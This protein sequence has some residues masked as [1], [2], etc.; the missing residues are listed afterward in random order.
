MEK[1]PLV[2]QTF[3]NNKDSIT[4]HYPNVRYAKENGLL[5]KKRGITQE[6][7][8]YNMELCGFDIVSYGEFKGSH[9]EP[10]TK[11]CNVNCE[12]TSKKR[13]D[14][15]INH[16]RFPLCTSCTN[17]LRGINVSY[18]RPIIAIKN[19]KKFEFESV[20]EASKQLNITPQNVYN[21]VRKGTP[22]SSGYRFEF[23]D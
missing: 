10:T 5:I 8:S 22:H 20:A 1:I 16:E 19:D 6:M 9:T 18:K 2:K 17:I 7:I 4:L 11:C 21:Y 3:A 13:Y 23:L 14:T 12:N 15:L